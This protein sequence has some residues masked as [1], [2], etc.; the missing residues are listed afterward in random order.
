MVLLGVVW[1]LGVS[2]ATRSDVNTIEAAEHIRY[3]SQKI[4]RDYLYLYS[5]PQR[6]SLRIGLHK[7]IQEL[8][9][10]FATI[11]ASTQD[12]DTKDLLK[13]LGYNTQNMRN[14]LDK[15]VTKDQA[16][17]MLD[18]SEILLE[19]ADSIA[20]AHRY[21]FS[22][23][24]TML[25]NIKKYEYLIERLGKFY[26]A[27]QLGAL[28]TTNR[29]KMNESIQ[30]LTKGLRTIRTYRYPDALERQKKHLEMFWNADQHFLKHAYDMFVPSI[31]VTTNEQ[32]EQILKQ[33]A[34]HHSKRQ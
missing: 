20:R 31:V 26:M 17:Q 29:K 5:R 13:Y 11:D 23:E 8:K 15:H 33:F 3:L 21:P 24:E 1:T 22:A 19:G 12:N 28:S 4:A 30:A 27:S 9:T 14:L 34:L 32:F 7:M 2:A 10:H 25:M 16:R 18:Y 6:N